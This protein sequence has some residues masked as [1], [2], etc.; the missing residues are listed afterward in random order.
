[1]VHTKTEPGEIL[2]IQLRYNK[3]H[4]QINLT[5]TPNTADLLSLFTD[6]RPWQPNHSNQWGCDV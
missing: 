6:L 5:Q 2:V 1:M 3:L 4:P